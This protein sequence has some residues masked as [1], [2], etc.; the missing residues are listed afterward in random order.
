MN[1]EIINEL[2]KLA[3]IEKRKKEIL[4]TAADELN[5]ILE[6]VRRANIEIFDNNRRDESHINFSYKY[7][8]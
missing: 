8:N 4:E 7:G 3:E 5:H 2:T 6:L 1:T